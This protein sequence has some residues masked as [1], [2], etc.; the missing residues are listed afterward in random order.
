MS[1]QIRSHLLELLARALASVHP[2]EP[3]SIITLER[4]KQAQFGDYSSA[5]AMQLA[6]R[7]RQNPKA[8]AQSLLN[9]LPASDWLES[10][11]VAG[12]GFINL[13]LKASA[14]Q[15]VV[16]AILTDGAEF[17]LVKPGRAEPVL[18]EFVS[19]NPTGPL[20]VGHG[21]QA[22]LGD[23][24]AAV[25][26]TQ[27]CH[28]TREFYSND[29]GVQINNLALSVQARVREH[30][31]QPGDFPA[32]GYH[33]EYIGELAL[34]FIESEAGNCENLE[35]IRTFSIQEQFDHYH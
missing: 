12:A 15:Q 3:A 32:D 20:H 16:S 31:G 18:L 27:G 2:D 10:A 14:K 28:V 9:A 4:C 35:A 33:G 22:A 23:S 1:V 30:L 34:K 7:L 26:E 5:L 25:L 29:A 24:L 21:R 8:L 6:R 11:E 17:G 13:K 19:A